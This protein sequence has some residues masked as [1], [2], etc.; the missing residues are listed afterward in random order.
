MKPASGGV[1]HV[2]F[3][4]PNASVQNTCGIFKVGWGEVKLDYFRFVK[5][6]A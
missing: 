4:I 6:S 5:T 3:P 1:F 2:Y